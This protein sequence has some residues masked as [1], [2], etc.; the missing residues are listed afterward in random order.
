VVVALDPPQG[1]ATPDQAGGGA[2]V[3]LAPGT[4][5]RILAGRAEGLSGEVVLAEDAPYRLASEVATAVADVRLTDGARVR[6]PVVHLQPIGG[7]L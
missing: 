4:P 1:E 3:P 6:V 7:W 5:V 2:G